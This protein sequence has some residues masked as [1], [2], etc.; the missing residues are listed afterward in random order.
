MK[1]VLKASKT[2]VTALYVASLTLGTPLL[3]ASAS[4]GAH[5]QTLTA[6]SIVDAA[7]SQGMVGEQLD[8]YIGFVS[9]DVSEDVRAA[10]NEINIK[11]KS[12]YTRI[13]RD[14]GVSVSDIAGLSGEQLV[15][16]AAIGLFIKLGDGQ[17]HQVEAKES[18][19]P[20]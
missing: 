4:I 15:A 7:K 18:G 19:T 16:K 5:A 13:A 14:K 12:L 6:K 11:R 2:V 1:N 9:T 17:W 10:V 20:R 3:F 8:G